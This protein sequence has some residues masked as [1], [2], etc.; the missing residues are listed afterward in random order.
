M[1]HSLIRYTAILLLIWLGAL[2]AGPA[3]AQ[4]RNQTVELFSSP[5]GLAYG[6]TARTSL[7][8][9]PIFLGGVTVATRIQLLDVE[10]ALIA[11]SDE[12]MSEPGKIKCWDV[13]RD[14]LSLV[15]EPGTGRVQARIRVLLTTKSFDVERPRMPLAATVELINSSTGATVAEPRLYNPYITV[16]Y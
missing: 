11:Q 9:D 16:D 15:G 8:F 4:Q 3:Q 2:S 13:S 14:Q 12:I 7:A 10:G 6:Q 1:R 5:F